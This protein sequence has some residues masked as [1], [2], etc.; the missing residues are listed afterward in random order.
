[1][2]TKLSSQET[3]GVAVGAGALCPVLSPNNTEGIAAPGKAL[4]FLLLSLS[5]SSLCI[6]LSGTIHTP[7]TPPSVEVTQALGGEGQVEEP[8]AGG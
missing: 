8:G 2:K 3:S 6:L 5:L 7:H 4:S 1:M